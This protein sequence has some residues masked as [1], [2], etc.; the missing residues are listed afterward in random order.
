MGEA[1]VEVKTGDS[2]TG[3]LLAAVVDR[4][5]GGKTI[6]TSVSSWDDV[7]KIME[8]WS[9]IL[10]FRLC[11]WRGGDPFINPVE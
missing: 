2:Q 3:E 8:I 11:E 4:R 9:K 5:V 6:K 7:N 1:S 10:R